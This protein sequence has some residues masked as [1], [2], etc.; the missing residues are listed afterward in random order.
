MQAHVSAAKAAA[1]KRAGARPERGYMTPSADAGRRPSDAPTIRVEEGLGGMLRVRMAG[2]LPPGWVG[3]LAQGL[4]Q[5]SVAIVRGYAC[6]AAGG[7]WDAYFDLRGIEGA[8]ALRS[9]DYEALAT[10]R[11]PSEGPLPIQLERY[12]LVRTAGGALRLDL[13]GRRRVGFLA[14]LLGHLA[15]LSLFAVDM[16]IETHG[17]TAGGRFELRSHAGSPATEE[18]RLALDR[19]LSS[20]VVRS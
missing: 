8:A 18:A 3:T 7:R 15:G 19:L 10:R 13:R 2:R 20:W 5:L 17:R 12:T 9:I 14:S 6:R 4:S 11:A 16:H 1:G